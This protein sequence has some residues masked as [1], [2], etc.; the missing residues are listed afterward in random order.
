M[1][2]T[3]FNLFLFLVLHYQTLT[4]TSSTDAS[5]RFFNISHYLYPK[6]TSFLFSQPPS[7]TSQPSF[8]LKDILEAIAKREKWDL[9]DIRV[10]KLDARRGKFRKL[11]KYEFGVRLGKT[12][13]VFKVFDQVSQWTKFES[14]GKRNWSDFESLVKEIGSKAVLDGFKIEG[15]LELYAAGDNDLTLNLPLNTSIPGLKQIL[16]SEGIT[17]EVEGAEEITVF[18]THTRSGLFYGNAFTNMGSESRSSCLSLLPIRVRGSASV[19]VY[20]T[21]NPD[22]SIRTSFLSRGTVKLLPEKCYMRNVYRKQSSVFDSLSQRVTSLENV[23]KSFLGGRT[24]RNT[25]LGLKIRIKPSY[26][27]RF[28]IEL[29][30]NISSNDTYWSTLGEWRTRPAA[31]R[32]WFEV[33]AGIGS[34]LMKPFTIRKVRPFIE[35]DSLSWSSLMSNISFTNFPSFLVPPEPLTLDVKW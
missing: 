30:R 8:F 14:M 18:H 29:E 27:F 20:R 34:G 9:E 13:F 31:E 22:A 15:P 19:T 21:K 5:T 6:A 26:I 1:V 33:V 12:E 16:V 23:L 35:V 10:S 11:W 4:L 32:V 28:Q 25:G 7:P 17:I 3:S 2:R 24:N